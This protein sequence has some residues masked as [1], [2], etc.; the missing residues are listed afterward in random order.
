[1]P[2]Y[3]IGVLGGG[4][5]QTGGSSHSHSGWVEPLFQE[6][7]RY[8]VPMGNYLPGELRIAISAESLGEEGMTEVYP[9]AYEETSPSDGVFTLAQ[10][11]PDGW[12]IKVRY[13]YL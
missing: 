4:G 7:K 9:P 11:M 1:M 3:E 5:L 10:E 12:K 2:L 6:P 8:V 13:T